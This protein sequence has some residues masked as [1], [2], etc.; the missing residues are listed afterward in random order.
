MFVFKSRALELVVAFAA[1]AAT[2]VL[3][4]TPAT[5]QSTASACPPYYDA[6]SGPYIHNF[7]TV[8][9]PATLL[10]NDSAG[11]AMWNSIAGS[12]PNIAPKGQLNGSTINVTYNNGA[13]PDCCESLFHTSP[14]RHAA[15]AGAAMARPLR[16]RPSRQ[17]LRAVAPLRKKNALLIVFFLI[18][19]RV[20]N[21]SLHDP[22]ALRNTL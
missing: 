18:S 1:F 7:P 15:L 10:A 19:N 3:A 14:T 2:P 11:Q 8:W 22:E 12:I 4:Q 6:A 9:T 13:D 20:D 5:P 21:H 17:H 16:G